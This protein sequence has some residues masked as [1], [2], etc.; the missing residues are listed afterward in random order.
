IIL[1]K[2]Y[3]DITKFL[4]K[5]TSSFEAD[6]IKIYFL[7]QGDFLPIEGM[8]SL[9]L[10]KLNKK[11]FFF[12][13]FADSPTPIQKIR[14]K[15][16]AFIGFGQESGGFFFGSSS[17]DELDDVAN[18]FPKRAL[19][20]KASSF[21]KGLWKA[22]TKQTKI[23][24]HIAGGWVLQSTTDKNPYKAQLFVGDQKTALGLESFAAKRFHSTIFT[25]NSL[26]KN[27]FHNIWGKLFNS[28]HHHGLEYAVISLRKIPKKYKQAFFYDFYY[29]RY[30]KKQTT[31]QAWKQA[32]D[33][34]QKGFPSHP[35][36]YFLVLYAD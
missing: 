9:F 36:F 8:L 3:P 33:R 24:L 26:K 30:R 22:F 4:Q 1:T 7:K 32:I 29:R 10:K 20:R 17:P 28:L 35:W 31:K 21:W 16:Y 11:V 19:F 34:I 5:V 25:D 27:H 15:N 23:I 13:G 18:L 12:R 6:S 14:A 2:K